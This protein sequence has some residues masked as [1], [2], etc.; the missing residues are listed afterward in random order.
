MTKKAT[1]FGANANTLHKQGV[2]S[3]KVSTQLKEIHHVAC[4]AKHADW[5]SG[6]SYSAEKY[7]C[8]Y[9]NNIVSGEV[10]QQLM[11]INA[12]ANKG[13]HPY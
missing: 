13:K 3:D 4:V 7:K 5:S 1:C 10:Y 9:D 12:D 11:K 6:L 8:G 2:I